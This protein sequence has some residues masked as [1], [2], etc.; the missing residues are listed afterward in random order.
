MRD[1]PATAVRPIIERL[2]ER[3]G[4]ERVARM[5]GVPQRRLWDIRNGPPQKTVSFRT[6]DRIVTR[7]PGPDAWHT[8]PTLSVIHVAATAT[9]ASARQPGAAD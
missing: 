7:G 9:D 4:Q 8:D 1:V 3:H 2:C 6:A 5:L